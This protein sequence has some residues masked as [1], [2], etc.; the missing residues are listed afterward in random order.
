VTGIEDVSDMN[1]FGF[2]EDEFSFEEEDNMVRAIS[3]PFL[4]TG[5]NTEDIP[6]SIWHVSVDE[7]VT[8]IGDGAFQNCR[9]LSRVVLCEGLGWIGDNAFE[10]CTSIERIIIPAN[11]AAIGKSA[12]Q[13]C[14]TLMNVDLA[15]R[16]EPLMIMHLKTAHRL[17]R[18]SSP[19]MLTTLVYQFSEIARSY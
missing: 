6:R 7:S 13:N 9:V 11:V 19:Q 15:A 1:I 8:V 18:S 12:F 3:E 2:E 4:Y 17:S 16:W 10:N 14:T 5:Q